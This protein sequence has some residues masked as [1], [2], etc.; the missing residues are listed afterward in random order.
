L[1]INLN[2]DDDLLKN[3]LSKEAELKGISLEKYI[4]EVLK[5][6]LSQ[7]DEPQQKT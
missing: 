2:F 4:A 7:L 1:H 5:E 3:E 6:Y